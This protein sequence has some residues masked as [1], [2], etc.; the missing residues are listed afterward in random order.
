MHVTYIVA[1][2]KNDIDSSRG[3]P[4]SCASFASSTAFLSCEISRAGEEGW[5]MERGRRTGWNQLAISRDLCY[6][7]QK[8]RRERNQCK[9]SG[10]F[11]G[12]IQSMD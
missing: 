5:R 11:R 6:S 10:N 8:K 1:D 9:S 3:V 2:I 12:K 7:N 4:W